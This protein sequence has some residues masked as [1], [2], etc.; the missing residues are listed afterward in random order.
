MGRV[1]KEEKQLLN[2]S[3]ERR[4]LFRIKDALFDIKL[5]VSHLDK[6]LADDL[7]LQ[8]DRLLRLAYKS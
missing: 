3:P 4:E 5:R 8:M 7:E 1:M 2:W 6:E